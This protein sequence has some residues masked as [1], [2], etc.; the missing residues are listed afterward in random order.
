MAVVVMFDDLLVDF[1]V[2]SRRSRGSHSGFA[3]S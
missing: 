2:N 3:A 1:L